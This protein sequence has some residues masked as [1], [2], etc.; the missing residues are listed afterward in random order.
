MIKKDGVE[1]ENVFNAFKTAVRIFPIQFLS[2]LAFFSA[3]HDD[4]RE[5]ERGKQ[6][7]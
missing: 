4:E 3:L 5:S 6:G 2:C 1:C 7:L